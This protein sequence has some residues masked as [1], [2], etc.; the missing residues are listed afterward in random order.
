MKKTNNKMA[1]MVLLSALAL[2]GLFSCAKKEYDLNNL[3]TEVTIAQEGLAL[4]LGSTKQIKVKDLLK[5]AGD[6]FISSSED[7]LEIS[8]ADT[9][10]L[11]N[12]LPKFSEMLKFDDINVNQSMTFNIGDFNADNVSI[13][14]MEISYDVSAGGNFDT[15]ISV[16]EISKNEEIKL[17]LWEY[18]S[19]VKQIDLSS[20]LA[21]VN[22]SANATFDL[23]SI[24]PSLKDVPNAPINLPDQEKSIAK[25][26]SEVTINF[27]SPDEAISNIKDIVLNDGAQMTVSL[28][29]TGH[30]FIKEGGVNPDVTLNLGNLFTITDNSGNNL[31]GTLKLSQML[32]GS[33]NFTISR[34]VNLKSINLNGVV[35]QKAI[36]SLE[37]SFGMTGSK[38]STSALKDADGEIG[39]TLDIKFSNVSVKSAT[40]DITGISVNQNISVPVSLGEGFSLPEHVKSIDQVLFTDN[41]S[42]GL[43]LKMKNIND[44]NLKIKMNELAIS[45]PEAMTV[46][47]AVNGTVTETNKDLTSG[48]NRSLYIQKIK[49]PAP[50]E[51]I[52]KWDDTITIAAKVEISGTGINSANFPTTQA[53]DCAITTSANSTL[54]ISNW[55]ATIESFDNNIETFKKDIE[56]VVDGDISNFG[57]FTI[58]PKGTPAINIAFALPETALNFTPAAGGITMTFPEFIKFK[59][60]NSAYN[61]DKSKNSITIKNSIPQNINLEIEKLVVSP[62]KADN[63]K[64][65]IKGTFTVDGG[66][67][68][69]GGSVSKND[70]EALSKSNISVTATVPPLAAQ[71]IAL[72]EFKIDINEKFLTTL[73]KAD[74]IPAEIQIKELSEALLDNVKAKFDIALKNLPDMGEGKDLKADFTITIPNQLVLDQQ[75]SRVDGNKLN[76]SGTFDKG[77]LAVKPIDVLAINMGDYDFKTDLKDTIK[78]EGKIS[79]Q[80]PEINLSELESSIEANINASLA[81]IKFSSIKGKIE[82]KLDDNSQVI[83]LEGLPD[84]ITGEGVTLDI[85]NPALKLKAVTNMGIPVKGS[86]SITPVREGVADEEGKIELSLAIDGTADYTKK[87]SVIYYIAESKVGMPVGYTFVECRNIR[88]LIQRIPDELKIT[89]NA[90]TDGNK[91]CVVV[92]DA[93]YSFDIQYAFVCPLAFGDKFEFNYQDT[94]KGIGSEI[95]KFLKGNTIQLGGDI[96]N[97]LPLELKLTIDMLDSDG[98]V[99]AIDGPQP[100]QTIK[101]CTAEGEPVNTPLDLTIKAG[102]NAD[103]SKLESLLISFR[104]TSGDAAGVQVDED[105]Y[106]QASLKLMLPEGISADLK[107][108]G[109]GTTNSKK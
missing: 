88:P 107:D 101:S 62:E 109:L 10:E 67:T 68:I 8:I 99:I 86:V 29:L 26:E 59:N 90:E 30:E 94:L 96:E 91:E 34:K 9:M 55:Y 24:P 48:Y 7:G 28:K 5:K 45:F 89:F 12:N 81:D 36:I 19:K 23:P 31:N 103:L 85:A 21:D 93:K 57:T 33:N 80:N 11:G 95:G 71:S 61:Y 37:G 39:V 27:D 51:G 66:I 108:L 13:D 2:P 100:T 50:T 15:N 32:N 35:P 69:Q 65:A 58:T 106:V 14:G 43:N 3:N 38:T 83:K 20:S 84:I 6:D 70:V 46:K 42:I 104:A 87:D 54:S 53:N 63:G 22:M 64:S 60:V 56:Q 74:Q 25:Q 44:R 73:V 75:D 18:A 76:I 72:E 47:N 79:V 98:K 16:P 4:P 82:Y 92:P 102:K 40:F 78:V 97:Q 77:V 41:S 49:L 105:S 17:G 52:V 1:T